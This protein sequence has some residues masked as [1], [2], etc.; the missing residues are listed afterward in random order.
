MLLRLLSILVY[1][2]L[3]FAATAPTFRALTYSTYLRDSFT[4]TAIATDSAGNIYLAGNAI[5]DASSTQE[6]VLVLKLN[7]QAGGYLYVRF[8]GGSVNDQAS[9]I[10]VDS[11]GNAYIAGV[12]TSPDFPVT[13]TSNLGTPPASET[14]RS[15]VAKLDPNGQL[16]F[17]TLLGGSTN[18]LAQ[19]VAV[20]ASGQVLVSGTSVA[21][22]FPSTPG[23]YSVSDTSFVPYLLELDA[24]GSKLIFSATGIG[25][26]ALAF[27]SSGNIYMAGTTSSLTYPTTPGTYQPTFPVFQTCFAPCM[28]TF[29]GPNQYVTKLDS[30]GTKMIFSTAVSGNGNTTNEGLAVDAAGNVYLTGLAGAG[31]PYTV[32]APTPPLAPA[33]DLLA[34]PALPFLSKLDPNGQKL[35]YSVPVGGVGVQVDSNGNA[36]VG[37]VLGQYFSYDVAA[38]LPALANVPSGCF[39]PATTNGKSAYAAQVDSSG[40]VLGSQFI[41]GSTLVLSGVALSGTTLWITG[42]TSLQN[43][44]FTPNALTSPASTPLPLPGA[45]LGA[46]NFSA[47]QPPAGTPQIGCIVDAA[48]LQPA[49]PIVPY[50]LLTIFGNGLGPA[51]PVVAT[52]NSTT[53]L[54]GV[55]VSFGSLPAP[56]L[57]VSPNQINLAVPL[58]SESPSGT[59]MQVT[60]NGVSSPPLQFPVTF[61]NPSLFVVPGSYNSQFQEFEAVALNADGS[62]NSASNPAQLGSVISV[63]VNGLSPDPQVAA[64]PPQL[65]TAA[66][67]SITHV[68][69]VSPFVLQVDL[70]VPATTAN[71]SCPTPNPTACTASFEINDFSPSVNPWFSAITGPLRILGTVYV[72]EPQ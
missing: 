16:V 17:S 46:V 41:G 53:S 22:G 71:F 55:S 37:G 14:E 62:T 5:V 20:N 4:P 66:G 35:L 24:T 13:N 27:D 33:L 26:N 7:P 47:S 67:W 36:Y 65:F 60:V 54:G 72:A 9:A 69:D 34:T 51:T 43:F 1:S 48:D 50:Q 52:D 30:T 40:N 8:L 3:A 42:A 68:S 15:F 6:T 21:P 64:G 2:S 11:T 10:A 58:V 19:A 23:V 45:Y 59:V 32:P 38:S 61:A 25:G 63:F 39:L 49:G 70:R 12:T 18:S 29:Q 31:Y 57:Y 56:L 28:A 44:L